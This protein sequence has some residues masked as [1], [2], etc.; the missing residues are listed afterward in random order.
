MTQPPP[1]E[2]EL[3][4]EEARIAA[5]RAAWRGALADGLLARHLAP[6]TAF[7]LWTMFAAI[8]GFSGL[9]SR[10][11]AEIGLILGACAYMIYRLWTRR[12]F[13]GARR[14][15]T[16]WAEKV[17]AAGPVQ[18]TLGEAGFELSGAVSLAHWNFADGLELETVGEMIYVW[19][20]IGDPAF[21]PARAHSNAE[22]GA[23]YLAYARKRGATVDGGVTAPILPPR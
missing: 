17:R 22:T 8:L 11:S 12:R 1:L 6:L 18:I 10:H 21:W 13:F 20:R 9:I 3:T 19:P 5:A 4:V 16:K 14:A 2:F 7:A 15:A 23:S